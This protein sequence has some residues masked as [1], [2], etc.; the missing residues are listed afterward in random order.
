MLY[1]SAHT[2]EG[3]GGNLYKEFETRMKIYM[4]VPIVSNASVLSNMHIL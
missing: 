2:S 4:H 1:Y 3:I